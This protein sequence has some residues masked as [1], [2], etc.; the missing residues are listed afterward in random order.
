MCSV[1]KVCKVSFLRHDLWALFKMVKFWVKYFCLC[2]EN[3]GNPL[4]ALE[5]NYLVESW[6]ITKVHEQ[7]VLYIT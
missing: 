4:N 3:W 7:R 1:I 6:Y 2:N 5:I